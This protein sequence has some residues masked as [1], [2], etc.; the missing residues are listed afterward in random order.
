M[1]ASFGPSTLPLARVPRWLKAPNVAGTKVV[2]RPV[3]TAQTTMTMATSALAK[4]FHAQAKAPSFLALRHHSPTKTATS[5][6]A[7]SVKA[8]SAKEAPVKI[9]LAMHWG[10]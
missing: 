3:K 1:V 10:P 6:V 7:A 9:A 2:Q 4:G 8:I 5:K